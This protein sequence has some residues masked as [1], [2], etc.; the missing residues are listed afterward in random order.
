MQNEEVVE[1]VLKRRSDLPVGSS[2]YVVCGEAAILRLRNLLVQFS[3]RCENPSGTML[4]LPYFLQKPG[5]LK[6]IPYLFVVSRRSG[7]DVSELLPEDLTGTVL[8]L[9]YSLWGRGT[10]AYATNDRSGS[11][12]LLAQP[13]D[14]SRIATLV[15]GVLMGLGARVVMLSF[16][17]IKAEAVK[18]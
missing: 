17:G 1:V 16:T 3:E 8:L 13:G 14:R 2:V 6:R 11:G 7:V 10:K 15:C 4:D 5:F 12:T 18:Q 9:E